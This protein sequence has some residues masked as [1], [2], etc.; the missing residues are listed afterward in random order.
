MNEQDKGEV[1]RIAKEEVVNFLYE[2]SVMSSPSKIGR[3]RRVKT[4]K[5]S[6]YERCSRRV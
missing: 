1:R 4:P 2:Q 3:Y 6:D 5:S